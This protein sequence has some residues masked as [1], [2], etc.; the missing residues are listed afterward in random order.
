[1]P[2]WRANHLTIRVNACHSVYNSELKFHQLN[3][4]IKG[5]EV[6]KKKERERENLHMLVWN[7]LN[8]ERRGQHIKPQSVEYFTETQKCN[9]LYLA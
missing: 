3:E 4:G 7:N 9:D 5:G 8:Q 6:G 1:M 2:P